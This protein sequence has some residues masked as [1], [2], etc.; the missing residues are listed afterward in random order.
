MLNLNNNPH[1]FTQLM[2]YI[3]TPKASH[4]RHANRDAPGSKP[5]RHVPERRVGSLALCLPHIDKQCANFYAKDLPLNAERQRIRC[6]WA[7]RKD[8]WNPQNDSFHQLN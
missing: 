7:L 6:A 3:C 4:L 1:N 2:P 8:V 5:A